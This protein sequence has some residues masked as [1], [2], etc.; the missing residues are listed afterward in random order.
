MQVHILTKI[1]LLDYMASTL[2]VN[3]P[4]NNENL[5]YIST[6]RGEKIA[7]KLTS[8]ICVLEDKGYD[9]SS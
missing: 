4:V 1:Q 3:V 7:Y 6:I 9:G 5:E 2:K 8:V